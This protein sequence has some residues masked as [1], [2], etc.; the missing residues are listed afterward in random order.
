MEV[1]LIP[2]RFISGLQQKGK[3]HRVTN[4]WR[5]RQIYTEPD[6]KTRQILS[7]C[8]FSSKNMKKN[9]PIINNYGEHTRKVEDGVSSLQMFFFAVT[10]LIV[11]SHYMSLNPEEMLCLY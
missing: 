7:T 5:T 11:R 9:V 1:N 4:G 3:S 2:K 10:K 6:R 8:L